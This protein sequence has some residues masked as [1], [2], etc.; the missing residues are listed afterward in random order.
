MPQKLILLKSIFLNKKT[1]IVFGLLVLAVVLISQQQLLKNINPSTDSIALAS[2]GCIS[3]NCAVYGAIC[4]PGIENCINWTN[5]NNNCGGCGRRCIN[6]QTCQ[7]GSCVCQESNCNYYGATCCNNQCSLLADNNNCGSC[8]RRCINGQTCQSGNC[9]CQESNCAVYGT[10]CCNNQC[11]N[12][13][14]DANNC[15]SCGH[16]CGTGYKCSNAECVDGSAPSVSITN[17]ASN[18]TVSGTVE[19]TTNVSDPQSSVEW[20]KF[21]VKKLGTTTTT[22]ICNKTSSCS[23]GQ[24]C[25]YTCSWDTTKNSNGTYYIYVSAKSAGGTSPSVMRTVKV[26]NGTGSCTNDCN[27]GQKK[28]DGYNRF[29]TCGQYDSDECLDWATTSTPCPIGQTCSGEGVCGSGGIF[30]APTLLEPING[31]EVSVTPNFKWSKVSGA[32]QY[33][34]MVSENSN[35]SSTWFWGKTAYC[36]TTTCSTTWSPYTNWKAK[37][38][39]TG[40]GITPPSPLPSLTEGKT[41]YWLAWACKSA[42]D[43]PLTGVSAVGNFRIKMGALQVPDPAKNLRITSQNCDGQG[44]V[45]VN[46]SWT[47]AGTSVQGDWVRDRQ[48]LDLAA[49]PGF[50]PKLN[51][52][53]SINQTLY[54]TGTGTIGN[55]EPGVTHYWLINTHYMNGQWRTS[56][57]APFVTINCSHPQGENCQWDGSVR[58]CSEIDNIPIHSSLTSVTNPILNTRQFANRD[59]SSN[60]NYVKVVN[61]ARDNGWNPAFIVSLWYEESGG[62]TNIGYT[63]CMTD[64]IT[65]LECWKRSTLYPAVSSLTTDFIDFA[66]IQWCATSNP[67]C[68]N[69]PHFFMN[70]TDIYRDL[71]CSGP[72]CSVSN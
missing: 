64:I 25:K 39:N 7:S 67:V 56:S 42:T 29:K 65:N 62:G 2:P 23:P 15:G 54:I 46:F 11:T 66:R 63:R 10:T 19:I 5:D 22:E 32:T 70:V 40:D 53:L 27:T 18:A 1:I 17:P 68:S 30:G 71:T 47:L 16:K 24:V 44:K 3:A 49:N 20:A 8:G 38:M 72:N 31:A 26:S 4:C 14:T 61:W 41:Y 34:V 59:V 33:S 57:T 60:P 48:Y 9:I 21:S 6:G 43:C 28:C 50:S 58:P 12:Y 55:L 45:Q 52:N 69:N 13:Y 37:D 35:M 36:S 51:T